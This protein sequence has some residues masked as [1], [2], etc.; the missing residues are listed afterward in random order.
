MRL[1]LL[2][3]LLCQFQLT[4][5]NDGPLSHFL[6]DLKTIESDFSQTLLNES[7]EIIENS[8]GK[9][10]LLQPDKFYWSY[11]IP[12]SQKI[13]SDGEVLWIFDEDLEQ[14]TIRDMSDDLSQTPAGIILGNHDIKQHFIEIDLGDID[15]FNWIELTPKNIDSQ[16]QSIKIGFDNNKLGMLIINDSLGQTTRIDFVD[17][18]RNVEIEQDKFIFTAPEGID[19]IDERGKK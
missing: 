17:V 15:G 4:Y 19:V 1:I 16:Y 18:K 13:I 10:Y 9:L 7:G 3:F 11:Q 2:L 8:S 12:Y 5:G 6:D 14:V